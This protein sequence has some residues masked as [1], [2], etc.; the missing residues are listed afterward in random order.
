M[1]K[2][3]EEGLELANK[4]YDDIRPVVQETVGIFGAF[5]GFFNHV[6]AS[7]L[8]RLNS[9]LK[10]KTKALAQN[11][12]EKYLEIPEQYRQEASLNIWG[13][14][15]EALKWSLD[16]EE[17]KKMFTHLLVNSMDS[18]IASNCHPAYVEVIKQLNNKDAIL[19]K[20]LTFNHPISFLLLQNLIELSKSLNSKEHII[21]EAKT[22]LPKY[23]TEIEIE[24]LSIWDIS[25]SFSSLERLGVLKLETVFMERNSERKKTY[26]ELRKNKEILELF[27]E[28]ANL[29]KVNNV[30][31][32]L[33]QI[34]TIYE[35]TEFG[36]DFIRTCIDLTQTVCISVAKDAEILKT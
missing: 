14:T 10:I 29:N 22:P 21:Y 19:L 12:E 31:L 17:L 36:F 4:A 3:L 20:T 35:F 11:F 5:I 27:N 2:I 7:P 16:E 8:H 34:D 13:P 25:K 24:N 15:L 32:E 33:N 23:I 1:K 28:I 18:R 9:K 6:V 26:N 30:Y